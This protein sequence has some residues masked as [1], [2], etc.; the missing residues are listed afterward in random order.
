MPEEITTTATAPEA[1]PAPKPKRQPKP[2]PENL[3]LRTF[4]NSAS[5]PTFREIRNA[6]GL[7]IG[8]HI[9]QHPTLKGHRGGD[10]I[11]TVMA[12]R[13]TDPKT[14]KQSVTWTATVK[15]GGKTRKA[16]EPTRAFA[17]MRAIPGAFVAS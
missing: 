5:K 12:T 1:T 4:E 6:A 7:V 9:D 16:T 17:T 10:H 13:T 11:G 15:I 14:G 8:Y 3:R 2:K